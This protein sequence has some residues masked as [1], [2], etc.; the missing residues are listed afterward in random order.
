MLYQLSYTGTSLLSAAGAA[1]RPP[2]PVNLLD[3]Q[4]F[5]EDLALR[6]VRGTPD[7]AAMRGF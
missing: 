1:S 4:A 5:T 2:D 3:W 7:P 6:L